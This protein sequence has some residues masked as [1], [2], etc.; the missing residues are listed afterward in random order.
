[1]AVLGP[2]VL[3]NGVVRVFVT[4]VEQGLGVP[5]CAGCVTL[6]VNFVQIVRLQMVK[7]VAAMLCAFYHNGISKAAAGHLCP[8]V[9]TS[10]GES[11]EPRH[12]GGLWR[13]VS[14][15]DL[16]SGWGPGHPRSLQ[17]TG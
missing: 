17:G 7:V 4:Q 13:A 5:N 14:A 10:L 2:G 11:P 6:W 8:S 1:M 9:C 16:A 3:G 15:P 12:C